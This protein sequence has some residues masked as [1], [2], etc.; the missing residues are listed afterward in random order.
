MASLMMSSMSG[1]GQIN[2]QGSSG[3]GS[4]PEMKGNLQ[5]KFT[6]DC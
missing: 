6:V 1:T 2:I 5:A 3:I 4:G